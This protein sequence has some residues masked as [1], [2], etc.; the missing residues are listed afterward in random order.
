MNYL[1]MANQISKSKWKKKF[2]NCVKYEKDFVVKTIAE[3][4][5]EGGF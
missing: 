2:D 4:Y 3:T 5:I 1:E